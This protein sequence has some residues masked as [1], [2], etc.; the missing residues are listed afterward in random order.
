MKTIITSQKGQ[1]LVEVLVALSLAVVISSGI[2]VLIVYGLSNAQFSKSQSRAAQYAQEGMETVRSLRDSNLFD[3]NHPSILPSFP[4]TNGQPQSYCVDSTQKFNKKISPVCPVNVGP[5]ASAP[6]GYDYARE[7]DVTFN[8]PTVS[9]CA[10]NSYHI[11]TTVN[12]ADG[13]CTA[14]SGVVQLCHA[15]QLESCIDQLN[16]IPPTP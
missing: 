7:I 1:S 3:S 4:V 13:K 8:D 2:A 10:N 5:D 9:S 14:V 11:I 12:W 15:V 16:L 6:N